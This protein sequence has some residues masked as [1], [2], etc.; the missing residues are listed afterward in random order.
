MVG[1][2]NSGGVYALFL[3]SKLQLCCCCIFFSISLFNIIRYL[4]MVQVRY[5]LFMWSSLFRCDVC[6]FCALCSKK[7]N[8]NKTSAIFLK[9][10]FAVFFAK[11]PLFVQCHTGSFYFFVFSLLYPGAYCSK[12]RKREIGKPFSLL[13]SRENHTVDLWF[14]AALGLTFGAHRAFGPRW[15]FPAQSLCK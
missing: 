5:Y 6:F 7:T 12:E 2:N 3:M 13:E 1:V 14:F 15:T 4:R 8:T 11:W 9:T 10:F